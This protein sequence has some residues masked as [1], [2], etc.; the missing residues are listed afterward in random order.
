MLRDD[1][2]S[3]VDT[4][5]ISNDLLEYICVYIY[6]RYTI[7]SQ[8]VV[9]S[10]LTSRGLKSTTD[11]LMILSGLIYCSGVLSVILYYIG[12]WGHAQ[13]LDYLSDIHTFTEGNK[14]YTYFF[15]VY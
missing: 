4:V 10:Y 12:V 2:Y 1:R 3:A 13:G 6:R 8:V 14:T 7:Y 5:V 11:L 9:V 15:Y